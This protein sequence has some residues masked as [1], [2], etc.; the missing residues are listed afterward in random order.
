MTSHGRHRAQAMPRADRRARV[1]RRGFRLRRARSI[2][3]CRTTVTSHAA[4][5]PCCGRSLPP[6]FQT[7]RNAS[8]TAS[9][10]GRRHDKPTTPRDRHDRNSGLPRI[11]RSRNLSRLNGSGAAIVESAQWAGARKVRPLDEMPHEGPW[12]LAVISTPV[13]IEDFRASARRWT[14]HRCPKRE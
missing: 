11:A 5:V 9:G 8:C 7:Q 4:T 14:G 13:Q 6:L 10:R 1:E 12:V 3:R 2:A